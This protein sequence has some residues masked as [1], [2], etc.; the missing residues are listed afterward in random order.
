MILFRHFVYLYMSKKLPVY[1]IREFELQ[2]SEGEFYANHVNLHVQNHRFTN[3]PHKH[4]FYL[5][6]L[7]TKGSGIHEIDFETFHVQPG[8]LFVLKPGEMHFWKLSEDIDGYVFFHSRDFYEKQA[9]SLH[10]KDFEFFSSFQSS[11]FISL[12][13]DSVMRLEQLMCNL[14]IENKRNE[15]FKW[16]WI[17]AQVTQIYIE[18]SRQYTPSHKAKSAI[19]LSRVRN[20]EDLIEA[21][22]KTVKFAK[23]YAFML[24]T[25]EK[26]LNR[27]SKEC[28]GKTSTQ[29]IGDRIVL[30]AKRM[31]MHAEYS[32]TQIADELGFKEVSYF[33][34]FFKKNT[35]VTPMQFVRGYMND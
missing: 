24:N 16:K 2:H 3:L 17:H 10:L 8:T 15:V 32:V 29:L 27:I 25:T 18:I 4:D 35:G 28:F 19:Y 1:S 30:E 22:F 34:R 7:F 11:P 31:L 9:G 21:H 33:I 23:D 12:E 14:L 26:H 20:F 6:I 5:V 13:K